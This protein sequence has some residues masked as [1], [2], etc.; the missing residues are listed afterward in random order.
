MKKAI[1][2]L[3]CVAAL[4]AASACGVTPEKKPVKTTASETTAQSTSKEE[5]TQSTG[6]N[7]KTP[8][9]RILETMTLE[10]K[11]GQLFMLDPGMLADDF[12]T[13]EATEQML[14]LTAKYNIGGFIFLNR[15]LKRPN[16]RGG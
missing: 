7:T 10:E 6:E 4:C 12:Y 14:N 9:E 16:K 11:V 5:Q 1:S 8:A 15:I 3:L 13:S 2:I